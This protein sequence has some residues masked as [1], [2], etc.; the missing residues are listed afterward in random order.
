MYRKNSISFSDCL[1]AADGHLSANAKTA[2]FDEDFRKSVAL[3]LKPSE[4]LKSRATKKV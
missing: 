1:I 4:A 2:T 3:C